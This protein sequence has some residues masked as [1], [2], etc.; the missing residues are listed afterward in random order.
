[1]VNRVRR[2]RLA[3]A[4]GAIQSIPRYIIAATA[5]MTDLLIM[6]PAYTGPGLLIALSGAPMYWYLR[7]RHPDL[8]GKVTPKSVPST[9]VSLL[10]QRLRKR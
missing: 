1:L 3:T 6:K 10:I 5:L 8:L 9:S 4:R 2:S 7:R